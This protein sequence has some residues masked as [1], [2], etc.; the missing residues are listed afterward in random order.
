MIPFRADLGVIVVLC[1]ALAGAGAGDVEVKVLAMVASNKSDAF[2]PRLDSMERQLRTLFSYR[3]YRLVSRQQRRLGWGSRAS[4][5][6]PGGHF[7]QVLPKACQDDEV[8]MR[9][10]LLEGPRAVLN[11]D[12]TLPNRGYFLMGGRPHRKGVL[13]ISIGAEA[14]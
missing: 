4:F 13:I 8:S 5:D 2:D 11:T 1:G 6:L 14:R 9:V 3:S 12:L 7:V 10:M